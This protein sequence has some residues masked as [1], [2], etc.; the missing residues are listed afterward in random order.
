MRIEQRTG[1]SPVEFELSLEKITKKIINSL[2]YI[3]LS[4]EYENNPCQV[5]SFRK[6]NYR[7]FFR[8]QIWLLEKNTMNQMNSV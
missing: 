1:F 7:F 6:K 3:L 4:K 2:S 8:K 5:V